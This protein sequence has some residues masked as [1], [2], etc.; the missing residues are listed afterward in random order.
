MPDTSQIRSKQ[1]INQLLENVLPKLAAQIH[2]NLTDVLTLF[3][4]FSLEKIID[5]WTKAPD[6]DADTEISIENGNVQQIGLRL[7]LEGFQ[8]A[9]VPPF[10]I[11]KDLI[12]KLDYMD[13]QIRTDKNNP[14][15]EK[16]YS[17][18][19]TEKEI[20]EIAKIWSEELIDDITGKL[21][22]LR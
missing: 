22:G 21:E 16:S 14:L 12:L 11:R 5:I 13:Y 2:H 1:T 19:W 8:G 18:K 9:D 17:D 10:D 6:A 3:H 20:S 7:K 4:D 15:A